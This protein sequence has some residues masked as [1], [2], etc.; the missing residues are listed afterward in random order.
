MTDVREIRYEDIHDLVKMAAKMHAE[1]RWKDKRFS[2]SGTAHF[3]RGIISDPNSVGLM[4]DNGFAGARVT[5]I[6][7]F[8]MSVGEEC[9]WFCDNHRDGIKLFKALEKT[10]F[11]DYGVD[12]VV[13]RSM[14]DD[15]VDEFYQ[16]QDYFRYEN[17][18]A[19]GRS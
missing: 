4:T 11:E 6:P 12:L 10:L 9:G 17:A 13:F 19:K 5:D 16:R 18:W 8:E 15:K 2:P 3:I 1:S 7:F 14:G